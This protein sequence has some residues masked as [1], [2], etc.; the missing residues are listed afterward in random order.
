MINGHD[1]YAALVGIY[2]VLTLENK[3][4]V[5]SGTRG[6]HNKA[7]RLRCSHGES[8]QVE[9]AGIEPASNI[10]KSYEI[11]AFHLQLALSSILNLFNFGYKAA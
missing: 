4:T 3:V 5:G 11:Q 1:N 2:V 10:S 9:V 7:V 6:C 8:F